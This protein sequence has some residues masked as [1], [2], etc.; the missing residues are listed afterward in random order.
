MLAALRAAGSPLE[1][2]ASNA[3]DEREAELWMGSHPRGPSA[4]VLSDGEAVGLDEL[5]ARAPA[6]ILGEAALDLLPAGTAPSVPF[7]FKILT[8]EMGLSIQAHPSRRQAAD[9]YE[10]ENRAGIALDA[11]HRNYRD[12]NH[13]PELICA[14]GDFWGLRGFRPLDEVVGE[15]VAWSAHFADG[16][17]KELR[18]RIG[19]LETSPSWNRWREVF[20]E[21]LR[22]GSST[23]ERGDM[24]E[25]LA[26]YI[27]SRPN[28]RSGTDRDD[29]YW[30][31]GELMRQFP[32]DPGAAAPLYLNLVHLRRAEAMYLEAG[33]LHAYL[34]GAGIEIMANSD[35]VL[36]SGCTVKH[37]DPDE[38]ARA[39]TF[40]GR[41]APRLSGDGES[42]RYRTTASEFELTRLSV[43]EGLGDA[44][45]P[46]HLAKAEGPMVILAIGGTVGVRAAASGDRDAE[47]ITLAPTESAFVDH[48]TDAILVSPTAG[49]EAFVAALPGVVDVSPVGGADNE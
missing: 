38:L 4:V 33:L 26:R 30:W 15:M 11:P 9:G 49:A 27:A 31:V 43:R 6:E 32:D 45:S 25:A 8:A 13:K 17:L 16:R 47:T 24:V 7:L 5:I 1:R 20:L 29:R 37:V 18:E 2:T 48:A 46:R 28:A 12:R 10:R 42:Y 21:V 41:A 14:L 19:L 35:N 3:T 34:Y 44:P 22:A 40:E 23:E 36:R 39:L